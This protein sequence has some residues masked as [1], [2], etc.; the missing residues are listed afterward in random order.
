MTSVNKKIF[1]DLL[2]T[3]D[4]VSIVCSYH[5]LGLSP[6][7]LSGMV[8]DNESISKWLASK[9]PSS[10]SVMTIDSDGDKVWKN[11]DGKLHRLDGPAVEW[12]N[13]YKFWYKNGN[14]HRDGDLPAVEGDD[15]GKWWWKNGNRHRDGDLPAIERA[16]GTKE[17]WKNGNK[18]AEPEVDALHQP[19]SETDSTM[20]V[21]SAGDKVWKNS[22]GE[23][24]R[25]DG[26]AV[27]FADGSKEWWVDGVHVDCPKTVDFGI[28]DF[29]TCKKLAQEKLLQDRVQKIMSCVEEH[30]ATDSKYVYTFPSCNVKEYVYI[31]KLFEEKGYTVEIEES[32]KLTFTF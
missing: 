29:E 12:V 32:Y 17:W 10:D 26:P 3:G 28:V 4:L 22:D 13:G 24:H 6:A 5:T 14:R 23:L 20:T 8:S 11:S 27:E 7:D 18:I 2:T 1:E 9:M 30:I 19:V 16:D 21:D 25:L 15:G 31:K